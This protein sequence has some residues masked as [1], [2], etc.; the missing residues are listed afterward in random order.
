MMETRINSGT[1]IIANTRTTNIEQGKEP[2][3]KC[4]WDRS[5]EDADKHNRRDN[6]DATTTTHT[7]FSHCGATCKFKSISVSMMH[8]NYYSKAKGRI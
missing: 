8:A 7:R 5:D 6:N 3:L 4:A 1:K 2:G